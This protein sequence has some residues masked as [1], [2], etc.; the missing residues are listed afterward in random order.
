[1]V[2]SGDNVETD[3]RQRPLHPGRWS[4][5]LHHGQ[6]LIRPATVVGNKNSF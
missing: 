5:R 6:E 1:V 3:I 4:L 2:W